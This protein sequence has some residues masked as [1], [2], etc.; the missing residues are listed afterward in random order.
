MMNETKII[1]L[2]WNVRGL[3]KIAKL[4][5]VIY[6]LKQLKASVVSLQ[7]THLLSSDLLKI[8]RRWAGQVYSASYTSN[9]RGVITL[10]HK[11]IPFKVSKVTP[12]GAGR[13]LI[14][15]GSITDVNINLVN[16][17]GPNSDNPK[18]FEELFLLLAQMPGYF[19][20]GGDF[21][22]TLSIN[23]DRLKGMDNTHTQCRKTLHNFMQDLDLCD[24]WRRKYPNKSEFSCFSSSTKSYSHIDYF[25]VSNNTRCHL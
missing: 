13:Y 8:Q 24:P 15:Q 23:L 20:I 25:L 9:A 10:I 3:G 19:L 2:S 1:F 21:N 18:F 5:Q 11:S 14:L 22:T 4:K 7:E 6:R 16:L 17:Y 12:D